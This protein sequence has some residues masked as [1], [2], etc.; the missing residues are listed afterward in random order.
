MASPDE[1]MKIKDRIAFAKG[2][3]PEVTLWSEVDLLLTNAQLINVFSGEIEDQAI[4]IAQGKVVGLGDYPARTTI[5]L[6]G[7][8]I[9]P[10]LIDA[11]VHIES[12][13]VGVGGY[14]R[15]VLPHGVTTVV[16]DFHEIANV[17]GIKGI[18]LMRKG[19]E[20][21]PLNLFVMLPSCVPATHA[22]DRRGRDPG[23]RPQR[24]HAGRMGKGARR[25]DELPRRDPWRPRGPEK[26]RDGPRQTDRRPCPRLER[27][28]AGRLYL[29]P[30]SPRIMNAQPRQRPK[31]S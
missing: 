3:K 1:T 4:A 20:S 17:M 30:A 15:A 21:I 5:D 18:E 12:S 23:R 14:A 7:R 8:Y 9:A 29:L 26:D 25:D 10:G 11:H 22:R 24:P 13:M 27:Q 31:K 2:E 6:Q 16:T 28:G 19:I